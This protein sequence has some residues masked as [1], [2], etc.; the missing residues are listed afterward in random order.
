MGF[1]P[2]PA[3]TDIF[4]EPIPN[5]E[6]LLKNIPS[7][8]C[9]T[10]LAF[11]NAELYVKSDDNNTQFK[12]LGILLRRQEPVLRNKIIKK[13]T[14]KYK[15]VIFAK[16]Y[17]LEFIHWELLNY[18]VFEASDG[19]AEADL[20][21]LKAYLLIV[22]R[23]N[24]NYTDA[25]DKSIVNEDDDFFSIKTWPIIIEQIE[26]NHSIYPIP[27]MI[28][29]MIFLNYL[30]HNS[31]YK[32]YVIQFL[33]KNG[34][35]T[36]WD[37]VI[38]LSNLLESGWANLNEKEGSGFYKFFLN[39][40]D[41]YEYLLE[42][43]S[44]NIHEYKERYKKSKQNFTGFKD[45][46]LYKIGEEQYL[47]LNWNYITNKM[48]DG[49][50]FDFYS[51][52][53][54]KENEKFTKFEDLKKYISSNITEK[55]TFQRIV[56]YIFKSRYAK[57]LFDNGTSNF[58]DAYVR[59][60][61]Y[62]YLFELKDTYISTDVINS[63]SYEKIKEHID[64][65]FNTKKKG[66]GQIVKQIKKLTEEPFEEKGYNELN[67][68]TRN[69]VIYPIIVYTDKFFRVYGINNYLKKEFRRRIDQENLHQSFNG[70]RDLTFIDLT[71]F[72]D[73]LNVFSKIKLNDLIDYFHLELK[74]AEKR[75]FR[76]R[77]VESLW[78][79]NENFES[80][81]IKKFNK[82]FD[83]DPNYIKE[84]ITTFN[85]TDNLPKG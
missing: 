64:I 75:H 55:Y 6:D 20:N 70:I 9:I 84:I 8:T 79:E 59:N 26:V 83:K 85:L 73:H 32:E 82:D 76:N 42:S 15:G 37:Y 14:A 27:E 43:L 17:N 68:K 61:K 71:F 2:T 12:I 52:S 48:Y 16:L 35:K 19:A 21:F 13:L 4:D 56:K 46:P 22:E 3:F 11:I 50:L 63:Y 24:I 58:P 23:I 66:I 18:R 1:T 40:S 30:E 74:K 78:K 57:V 41:R 47:V 49:L 54:I 72:L 77:S 38:G 51:N 5:L 44:L 29:G 34:M 28:K 69:I 80:I 62:I 25:I 10:F 53:G 65:K 7:E 39:K 33:N 45:K 36:G 81:V 67:L 60:G 31:P